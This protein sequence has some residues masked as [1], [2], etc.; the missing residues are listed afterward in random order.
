MGAVKREYDNPVLWYGEAYSVR[1]NH[2]G[3]C[4]VNTGPLFGLHGTMLQS[5][6]N[7]EIEFPS[8]LRVSRTRHEEGLLQHRKGRF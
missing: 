8:L 1:P 3:P 5:D 7:S 4:D 6:V 2:A